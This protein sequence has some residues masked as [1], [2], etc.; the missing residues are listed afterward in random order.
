MDIK[1]IFREIAAQLQSE[2]TQSGQSTHTLT[3]G[4]QRENALMKF[5]Q[6]RIPFQYRLLKGEIVS[7]KTGSSE[8]FDLII[9]DASR[10]PIWKDN[11]ISIVPIEG[12][13]GVIE[14]KSSLSKT[15]LLSGLN[16]IKQL[17]FMSPRDTC[18]ITGPGMVNSFLR[19][20]PFG[21]VFGY[22]LSSNSLKS[23][24]SNLIEFEETENR[25]NWPNALVV[26]NEGVIHH[27][28]F[29]NTGCQSLFGTERFFNSGL[30]ELR[31]VPLRFGDETLFEFTNILFELLNTTY[32][33]EFNPA[34]YRRSPSKIGNHWVFGYKVRQTREGGWLGLN[35]VAIDSIYNYI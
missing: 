9:F 20:Y 15:E 19:P 17:R 21:V 28:G 8:H 23:L 4:N 10:A 33:G 24:A 3:M 16:K 25:V 6:Q 13:C 26:L 18:Q 22:Q 27:L 12:V 1:L 5:L 31:V 7:S 32:I 11:G 30:T 29:Y 34:V 14:V 35:K 2:F